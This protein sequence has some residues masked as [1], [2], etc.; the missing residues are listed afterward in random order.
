MDVAEPH[1]GE[2]GRGAAIPCSDDLRWVPSCGGVER[3]LYACN[4]VSTSAVLATSAAMKAVRDCGDG[5]ADPAVG[6]SEE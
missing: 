2:L 1:E 3:G 5:G 4:W 6:G